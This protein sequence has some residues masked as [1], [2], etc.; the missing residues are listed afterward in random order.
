MKSSLETIG[1]SN[2][3][4]G[5]LDLVFLLDGSDSNGVES[6]SQAKT[7]M[8]SFIEKLTFSNDK[9]RYEY[10][11]WPSG[12]RMTVETKEKLFENCGY[13]T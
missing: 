6:F 7:F 3:Q 13:I 1:A 8:Q 4:H 10:I 12:I 11:E 9:S 5:K 2:L